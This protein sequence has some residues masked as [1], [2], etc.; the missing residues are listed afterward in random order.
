MEIFTLMSAV[1]K[2]AAA[3]CLLREENESTRGAI[4]TPLRL[5]ERHIGQKIVPER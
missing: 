3:V 4:S 2:P 5:S 1:E